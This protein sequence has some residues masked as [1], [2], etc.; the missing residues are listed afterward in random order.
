M[1][2]P[3]VKNSTEYKQLKRKLAWLEWVQGRRGLEPYEE[4]WLESVT[5][6]IQIADLANQLGLTRLDPPAPA[7]IDDDWLAAVAGAGA[8]K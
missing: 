1:S 5:A 4:E 3:V 2:E 8:T 6:Q 7:S